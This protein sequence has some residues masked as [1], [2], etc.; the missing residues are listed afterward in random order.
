MAPGTRSSAITTPAKRMRTGG[1]G[2]TKAALYR[3]PVYQSV[4]RNR[5][6]GGPFPPIKKCQVVYANV[7]YANITTGNGRYVFSVNGL[8]DPDFTGTGTQPLYFDQLMAIYNHYTVTSSSIEIDFVNDNTNR[9]LIGTCYVDD[10]TTVASNFAAMQ[11]PG[12]KVVSGN[13]LNSNMTRLRNFWKGTDN[14]GPGIEN[15][16]LFRGSISANPSEQ[17]Y[18]VIQVQDLNLASYNQPMR[19]TIRYN[20]VFSELRTIGDS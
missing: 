12:A 5:L 19:I 4:S 9:S 18:Y 8:F 6:Q 16:S 13:P 17:M 1:K 10:D 3:T 14:F 11:R 2:S 20:A 7:V 15:N